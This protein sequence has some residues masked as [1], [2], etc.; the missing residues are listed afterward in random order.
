MRAM[1]LYEVLYAVPVPDADVADG[2]VSLIVQLQTAFNL[3]AA[4]D[5]EY[6]VLLF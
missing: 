6:F 3:G 1:V 4:V 2:G 5:N